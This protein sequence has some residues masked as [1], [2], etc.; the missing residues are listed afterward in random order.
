VTWK[1]LCD[2]GRT[3]VVVTHK[4]G[5]RTHSC[6][7]IRSERI[8]AYFASHG[9]TRNR[10]PTK[11]YRAWRGAIGRCENPNSPKFP[12]YGGR[13][14]QVNTRWRSDFAAFLADVGACPSARHSLDRI[15]VNGN[16]EPGNC[17]WATARQQASN[18]RLNRWVD[19]N[20]TRMIL[21]DVARHFGAN[22]GSLWSAITRHG[23]D[24]IA[25][26]MRLAARQR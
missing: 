3:T 18:T 8:A 6:G 20:G 14:I 10:S 23:E 12:D 11:E 25:A 16:Y 24:P 9:A 1:C 4:L 22:Y 26:A 17:R 15:D 7:C 2:C 5:V 13:G 19:V 21:K